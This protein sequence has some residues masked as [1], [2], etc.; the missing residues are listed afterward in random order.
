MLGSQKVRGPKG[1]AADPRGW[2][3]QAAGDTAGWGRE[4]ICECKNSE[5]LWGMKARE[6]LVKRPL[7]LGTVMFLG[8]FFFSPLAHIN[9][10]RISL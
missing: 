2:Q 3:E 6:M 5:K 10:T 8:F 4:S 7:C 9:L 1:S